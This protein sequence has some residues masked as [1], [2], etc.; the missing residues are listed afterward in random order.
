MKIKIKKKLLKLKNIMFQNK[1]RAF[2]ACL[3]FLALFLTIFSLLT[4]TNI[5]S[6]TVKSL[7][8]TVGVYTSEIKSIEITSSN[9]NASGSW[10]VTK[11]AEWT[12]YEKARVTFDVTSI[13]QKGDK[14]KDIILVVDIS[15][16]MSGKKITKA[17]SDAKELIS[18]LLSDTNNRIALITFARDST[19]VSTLSNNETD[20]LSKIDAIKVS[21][22]TNYNAGLLNVSEIMKTYT[23]LAS[24]DCVVLFL[25]DGYPN[26]DTPNEVGTYE[27]LKDK[28]PYLTINGIQYEMGTQIIDA[29]KNISDEQYSATTQSLNSILF[30]SA[31]PTAKYEDFIVTDYIDNDYFTLESADDI[32]VSLGKVTLTTEDNLQKITWNLGKDALLTGRGAQMTIDLTKKTSTIATTYYPTNKK[33]QITSKLPAAS[34][35]TITSTKTPVLKGV[36][37]VS[38]DTNAPKGCSL[39]SISSEKYFAYQ[40]VQKITQEL[41]CQGYLFKGWEFKKSDED[42]IKLVN[43]NVFIMPEKDIT[44]V[45]TWS[46][47]SLK[48]EMD[49][50]VYQN[51]TLY[52][53]LQNEAING[54]L[55]KEYTG[56]HQDSYLKTGDEKIYH[57]YATTDAEGTE[58]QN[59][60]NV[61]FANTCWQMIRTTDTGGVKLL[62]NGV[63]DSNGAC[64]S[65]RGTHIGYS[66]VGTT[67]LGSKNAT[68]AASY[69]NFYYGTAYT[70]DTETQKFS[71]A[72]TKTQSVWSD[73]TYQD[74]IGKYTCKNTDAAGT[75]T[76][77]YYV[78]GY[79]SATSAYATGMT[80]KVS[81]S[82][83]GTV[84]YNN[85]NDSLAYFGYMYNKVYISDQI[86]K[87][88]ISVAYYP[89]VDM[90]TLWYSKKYTYSSSTKEY[91]LTSPYQ[92]TSEEELS[93]LIGTYTV[94]ST[95]KTGTNS[96]LYYVTSEGYVD[97]YVIELSNGNNITTCKNAEYG[98]NDSYTY[99]DG[100]TKL[101]T[102]KYK[103]TNPTTIKR[104]AFQDNYEAMRYKYLCVNATNNTCSDVYYIAFTDN[105]PRLYIDYTKSSEPIKY[106][107]G[108][109]YSNG[110]YTLNDTNSVTFW[111]T[112]EENVQKIN[113]AHYTCLN[114]TGV[115]TTVYYVYNYFAE[116]RGLYYIPLTNGTSVEGA[117]TEMLTA[118]DV[119]TT[120]S[121]LKIINEIWYEQNLLPYK[122]YI[123]DTIFCNNRSIENLNGWNPNGGDISLS[124]E[125]SG[126]VLKNS[127][128]CPNETDKFSVNNS[129]ARLKYPIGLMT[130][131]EMNLLNNNNAR[132]G[133]NYWLGTPYSFSQAS[134]PF[135]TNITNTGELDNRAILY[136][137]G[138]RPAI[139]L[140]PEATYRVGDGTMNNPY[141]VE[142]NVS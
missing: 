38:Y 86:E 126:K 104:T 94:L 114:E 4:K 138:L 57:Y 117:M 18:F 50:T 139:S 37:T 62:Y 88:E 13:S 102:G 20:L 5:L 65:D 43:E 45:A 60:N 8:E 81:Y 52:R 68:T 110:T 137:N 112:T 19:I 125:F 108:Y 142:T 70:Y 77:L 71:L 58:I 89:Q 107:N 75:C 78:T 140:A 41:S 109:T 27:M 28:Y 93:S 132:S 85:K 10:K 33:E 63:P 39:P 15:G 82:V 136:T 141:I 55:A 83:L 3:S 30:T 21:G 34:S 105:T 54:G 44:L 103:I 127:L 9:Y 51:K 35:E 66:S 95:S 80:G 98:C 134:W 122:N 129:K 2:L 23:K 12:G 90:T 87:S 25:T 97:L 128:A 133:T 16:S 67:T 72:G 29:I 120:D 91:K 113:N 22:I 17:K 59:K 92:V 123:E 24:R 36:Y 7:L 1:S 116:W 47:H 84:R 74:L 76:I 121:P 73:D 99:G 56:A 26:K 61:I 14:Y 53:V 135:N 96:S 118:D 131:E 111:D 48:K 130:N 11:S 64:G 119:N 46:K 40:N 106:S 124:L 49:G 32:K 6:V 79:N 100:Y 42:S 31:A 115:C 69:Y 101:S